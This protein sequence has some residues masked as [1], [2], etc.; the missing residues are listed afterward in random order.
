MLDESTQKELVG[1]LGAHLAI[2]S[3]QGLRIVDGFVVPIGFEL[4]DGMSNEILRN[5]DRM[6]ARANHTRNIYEDISAV[7]RPSFDLSDHYSE[8]LRNISRNDLIDAIRYLHNKS[9]QRGHRPALIIQRDLSAE[10]SGTVHSINPATRDTNEVLIE[11]NLWMNHTVLGGESEPDMILIDKNTGATSL[12]S[13]DEDEIC[14]S[15]AQIHQLFSLVRKIE[16]K[17]GFPI[18][19][20]WA[21]DRGVLYILRGKRLDDERLKEYRYED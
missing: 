14:L 20:D 10:T 4:V 6:N 13:N 11:A 12:E 21:Y 18:S 5:F 15:P 19:L 1:Q 2:L 3:R 7:I 8:T 16:R 9:R 17:M